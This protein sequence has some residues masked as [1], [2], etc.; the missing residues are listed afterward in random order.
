MSAGLPAGTTQDDVCEGVPGASCWGAQGPCCP[1]VVN[2]C[3]TLPGPPPAPDGLS[4]H[5]A[6]LGG[7]VSSSLHSRTSLEKRLACRRPFF[8]FVLLEPT[9][10]VLMVIL[11]PC[12]WGCWS[13]VL[14]SCPCL[15]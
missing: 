6:S 14:L 2:G 11:C 10:N 1:C 15:A 5:S 3:R 8:S 9:P 7:A 12:S 13:V 4:E